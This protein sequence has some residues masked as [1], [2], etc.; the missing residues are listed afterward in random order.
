L[1]GYNFWLINTESFLIQILYSHTINVQI[2]VV[3][4]EVVD[5]NC[6][7]KPT[8]ESWKIIGENVQSFMFNSK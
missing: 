3:F 4:L 2:F 1:E 6:F 7:V 5:M 8:F